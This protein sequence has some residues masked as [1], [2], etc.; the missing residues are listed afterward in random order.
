MLL[1]NLILCVV[2]LICTYKKGTTK[3]RGSCTEV[4]LPSTLAAASL[5]RMKFIM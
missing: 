2:Q 3:E 1:T 5:Y 4:S